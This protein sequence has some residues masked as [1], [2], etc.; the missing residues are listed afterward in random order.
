MSALLTDIDAAPWH[1]MF[2]AYGIATNTPGYLNALARDDPDARA[3]AIWH[4]FSVQIH[5]GTPWPSTATTALFTARLLAG[6]HVTEPE[7]QVSLLN[8][9]RAVAEA[10]DLGFDADATRA[11]AYPH[12]D[13]AINDWLE[14]YLAAGDNDETLWTEEADTADLLLVRAAVDCYDAMPVMLNYILELCD[15]PEPRVYAAACSAAAI[16]TRHPDITAR[17]ENLAPAWSERARATDDIDE[18]AALVMALGEIN[19]AP[20]EFLT[21]PWL[22][23]RGCAALAPA[24]WDDPAAHDVLAEL[25]AGPRAFDAGFARKPQ[26]FPMHPRHRLIRAVCEQIDD[27]QLLIP[28]INAISHSTNWSAS[29]GDIEP[30]LRRFFSNGWPELAQRTSGQRNLA[31]LIAHADNLWRPADGNRSAT[32]TRLRLPT[33]RDAWLH[34]ANAPKQPGTYTADDIR[35][36][37]AAMAIQ[38]RPAMYFGVPAA[39]PTLPDAIVRQLAEAYDHARAEG[40]VAAFVVTAISDLGFTLDVT[41]RHLPATPDSPDA[42]ASAILA[43]YLVGCAAGREPL[44]HIGLAAAMC[45]RVTATVYRHHRAHIQQFAYGSPLGPEVDAGPSDHEDGYFIALDLD[46]ALLADNARLSPDHSGS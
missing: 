35:I 45:A 19:A 13:R 27:E 24:L 39:D 7:T 8:F 25:I 41:G 6:G 1:R 21:D 37:T 14:R 10:S 11:T 31:R 40:A 46:P 12:D 3:A 2:H 26:Q 30:Y 29:Q 28:G 5:Q 17:R 16:L 20:R 34:V 38:R 33:D 36:L 18:R 4:L 44:L 32:L 23:V 15:A 42:S 22:V 9:L 43:T